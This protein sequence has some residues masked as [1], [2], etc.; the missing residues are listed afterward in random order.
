MLLPARVKGS[1]IPTFAVAVVR[2][3]KTAYAKVVG[4]RKVEEVVGSAVSWQIMLS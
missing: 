4:V 3:E 2:A 1:G